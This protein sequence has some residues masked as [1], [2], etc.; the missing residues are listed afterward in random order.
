MLSELKQRK[1]ERLICMNGF[2]WNDVSNSY[3]D[4]FNGPI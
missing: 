2:S 3:G 4:I 1:P